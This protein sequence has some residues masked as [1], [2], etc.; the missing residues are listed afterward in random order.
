[1]E[2]LAVTG[3]ESSARP[4]STG[5]L[6]V[7]L[8]LTEQSEVGDGLVLEVPGFGVIEA[9]VDYLTP[10]F[11]GLRSPDALYRFYGREAFGGT[12][13]AAHHLFEPRTDLADATA[14]WQRWLESIFG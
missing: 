10:H 9:V 4:G 13:D 8:G 6:K 3:P 2:Y 7:A 12:V 11:V 1:V 5:M 14:A